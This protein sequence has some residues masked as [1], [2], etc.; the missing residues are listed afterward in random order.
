VELSVLEATL[1]AA[2]REPAAGSTPAQPLAPETSPA[3]PAAIALSALRG[4]AEH[5]GAP[6]C[7]PLLQ[8]LVEAVL[9]RP[10]GARD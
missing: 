3:V 8:A 9:P 1:T 2:R 4:L 5:C 7:N 10:G 6:S